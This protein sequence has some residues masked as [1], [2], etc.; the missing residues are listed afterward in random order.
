L[1]TDMSKE[2]NRWYI[3]FLAIITYI[4][5]AGLIRISVVVLFPEIAI[6]LNLSLVDIGAVWGM[7]PLAGV[8]VSLIGGLLVD[9]FGVR[10][11][12]AVVCLLTGIIGALRGITTDFTGLA[13]TMFA[14][15]IMTTLV[16]TILPKVTA[17]WFRGRYL[18][19]TNAALYISMSFGGMIG[20]L[21]SATVLSPLLGG[22]RNVLFVLAIPPIIIGLLWFFTTR[23]IKDNT[24]SLA[25][26]EPVKLKEALS[27]VIRIKSV[28]LLGFIMLTQLGTVLGTM[29][30]IPIYLRNAGWTAMGADGVVTMVVG[31]SCIST[32][33]FILLSGKLKSHKLTLI[34]TIILTSLSLGLFFLFDGVILWIV[35]AVYSLLRMIPLTLNTTII[36]ENEEVGSRYAGTAIGLANTLGMLGGFFFPMVGNSLAAVSPTLPFIFWAAMC[37]IALTGLFFIKTKNRITTSPSQY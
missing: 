28:W 5:I 34:L 11:T 29:A 17:I 22:W 26:M 13:A 27:H 18:A 4:F 10:K 15:G 14:F 9:R 36:I 31:A 8:F 12:I 30:Y 32:I 21:L 37:L 16:P 35:L 25:S 33:P 20:T 24:L 23:E 2:N 1:N 6:D 3:L 7:D 19:L